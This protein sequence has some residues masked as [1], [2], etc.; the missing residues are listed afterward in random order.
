MV[1]VMEMAEAVRQQKQSPAGK[2]IRFFGRRRASRLWTVCICE[3]M[4]TTHKLTDPGAQRL[5]S[6]TPFAAMNG[7]K[8][9]R[10]M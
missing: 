5:H 7:E 10:L 4:R 2:P 6:K 9:K 8:E 1:H 3:A